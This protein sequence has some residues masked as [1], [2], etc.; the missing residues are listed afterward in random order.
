MV[1]LLPPTTKAQVSGHKFLE[2][3]LLH[4]L[5]LGDIRMIHDPL[6][7]R[8]RAFT[9]G[10]IA[11][12]IGII[13]LLAYSFFKPATQPGEAELIRTHAG[14]LYVRGE[15]GQLHP[16]PN[17]TSGRLLLG[18]AVQPKKASDEV[19]RPIPRGQALGILDAPAWLDG[20]PA[21][22]S[23]SVCTQDTSI[24]V[25]ARE[26]N[27]GT[28]L[29]EGQAILLATDNDLWVL[30]HIGRRKIPEGQAGRAI[31]DALGIDYSTP[32]WHITPAVL[33]TIREQPAYTIPKAEAY[34]EKWVLFNNQVAPIHEFHHQILAA[35]GTPKREFNA[36]TYERAP[37]GLVLP[38]GPVEF[39][40]TAEKRICASPTETRFF[41]KETPALALVGDT[42]ATHYDSDLS[43]ALPVDT[44]SG[45]FVIGETGLRHAV[46]SPEV[47]ETIGATNPS[48]VPW[49]II[50]LLPAGSDLSI[51]AA[52]SPIYQR[53]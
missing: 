8:Q 16:V 30:D 20:K 3:R 41:D 44:G 49:D 29:T 43:S 45:L 42:E 6:G 38:D 4:G 2:K 25:Q 12:I 22:R 23:W 39:Q 21:S 13:A 40:K 24:I 53:Y 48:Q 1:R 18:K 17:I 5:V 10:L 37:S 9:A 52:R 15:A 51:E 36:T 19:L 33:A 26:P 27:A 47:M 14:A 28:K 35:L 7:R 34:S 46:P 31:Q 11:S 50:R 32:R